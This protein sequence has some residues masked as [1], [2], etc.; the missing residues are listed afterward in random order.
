MLDDYELEQNQAYKIVKGTIKNKKFSHAYIIETN[1]Y[2]KSLDFCLALA[3]SFICP[4]NYTN[5]NSCGISWFT[6]MA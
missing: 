5:R 3:K 2:F 4:R 6:R 1:N